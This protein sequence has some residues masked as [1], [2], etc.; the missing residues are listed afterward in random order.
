MARRQAMM[1]S[2]NKGG[3]APESRLALA[4]GNTQLGRQA[5]HAAQ[6]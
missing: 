1:R 2:P 3:N 5:G 4:L 6:A